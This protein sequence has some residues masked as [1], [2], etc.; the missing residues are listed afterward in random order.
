MKVAVLMSTYNGSH[1]LGQQI[2]SILAQECVDV[3][4]Y[5]RDDGSKDETVSIISRYC[6]Q[7]NRVHFIEGEPLGVG[8]SFMALL[9]NPNIQADYYSF[10]DQDD[11]WYP[12]KLVTA[13]NRLRESNNKNTLYCCNQNCIDSNGNFQFTRFPKN[14]GVPDFI[15]AVLKNDFAGCTMVM[16]NELR[17]LLCEKIPDIDFF[18]LRI[19]DA[20]ISC[21]ATTVGKVIF[22]SEPHMDFRRHSGTFSEE[23][24]NTSKNKSFLKIFI[25]KL[26]R[27]K[28]RGIKQRYAVRETSRILL[29]DF[30]DYIPEDSRKVVEYLS[31]Y[32]QSIVTKFKLLSNKKFRDSI[33][34]NQMLFYIKVLFNIL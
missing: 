29:S 16:N 33:K 5:I 32:D 10:S 23:A 15:T 18:Q 26:E 30:Y 31:S 7:D 22:D 6:E 4:L 1:Y 19:H 14:Y 13:V 3:D 34:S 21:I 8:K 28:K 24:I 20:W 12:Q 9:C 2:D 27:F 17:V 11:I 25:G